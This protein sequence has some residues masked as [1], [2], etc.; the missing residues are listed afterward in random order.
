VQLFKIIRDSL[1]RWRRRHGARRIG[2][3]G[4]IPWNQWK[5][6]GEFL[7]EAEWQEAGELILKLRLVKSAEEVERL[8]AS[9]RL[10]DEIYEAVLA[11]ARPG[12]TELDLRNVL[13]RQADES[14][15]DGPSFEGIFASGARASMPHYRPTS[16]PLRRR[17]LLL[18]DMGMQL[19]GYCSDMT[20]VV[21]LGERPK[22]RL[23]KAFDAVLEAEEKAMR[24]VGP[25]VKCV[26]LHRL[27]T[28]SLKRRG[29]AR[30]FTHGLGHGVGLEIH[31][32]PVLNATSSDVLRAGM[33]VTIEPGVYLPSLGGVRIEDM[34]VV[35][36][37]GC[38]SLSNAA[39][40]FRILPFGE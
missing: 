33:V 39:K 12:M 24:A 26:E 11:A 13:H 6:F 3:E 37:T 21:A 17:D 7:P 18:L 27:A 2:F 32:K 16:N 8:A 19:E 36:R 34:V 25:G 9:A 29:F 14:G 38:R 31:E 10:N 20:R 23:M 40:K 5:Q 35:T 4:S 22:A 28:S 15:A 1:T 30:Y